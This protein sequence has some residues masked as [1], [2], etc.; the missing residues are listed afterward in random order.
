MKIV[1]TLYFHV[2]MEL[3][4]GLFSQKIS[5]TFQKEEYYGKHCLATMKLKKKKLITISEK[6]N[7]LLHGKILKC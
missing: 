2:T 4:Q 1:N 5:R 7:I 6:I 3:S